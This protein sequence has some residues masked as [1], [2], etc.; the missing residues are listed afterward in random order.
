M[1]AIS[2]Q[3]QARERSNAIN[4]GLER[5]RHVYGGISYPAPKLFAELCF[6]EFDLNKTHR[7]TFS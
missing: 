4:V 6:A 2:G 7:K 1:E 5:W 3:W